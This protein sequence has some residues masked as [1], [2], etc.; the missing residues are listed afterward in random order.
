M[1][2]RKLEKRKDKA[3]LKWRNL[4]SKDLEKQIV[5]NLYIREEKKSN[6][7]RERDR[8]RKRN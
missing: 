4:K 5:R 2:K 3:E 8:E 1:K 7:E 6:R